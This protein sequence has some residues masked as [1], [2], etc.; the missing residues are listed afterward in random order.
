MWFT[1]MIEQFTGGIVAGSFM[2]TGDTR[3]YSTVYCIL[4]ILKMKQLICYLCQAN[5]NFLSLTGTNGYDI[6]HTI[7][8]DN[9]TGQEQE[10]EKLVSATEKNS[11]RRKTVLLIS[12]P[13]ESIY[14]LYASHK[15]I[16]SHVPYS[17]TTVGKGIFFVLRY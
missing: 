15:R 1:D 5:L 6:Y 13:F 17:F 7:P 14:A 3:M 9:D 11:H 8:S 12:N 4:F 16:Q 2:T 10:R